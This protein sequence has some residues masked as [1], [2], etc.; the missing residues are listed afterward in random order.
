MDSDDKDENESSAAAE[1]VEKEERARLLADRRAKIMAQMASAQKTFMSTNAEMFEASNVTSTT[2]SKMEWD[3]T[4]ESLDMA[5]EQLIEVSPIAL[6]PQRKTINIEDATFTCILCSEDSVVSMTGPCMVYSAFV[7][8]SRVLAP[9]KDLT[10]SPHIGSCGHVMHAT[11]WTKYFENEMQKEQRR[12]NRNRAPGSFIIDRQEF[13]CPLCRCLSNAVLPISPM[14]ARFS[15]TSANLQ[16]SITPTFFDWL[17][18]LELYNSQLQ[19]ISNLSEITEDIDNEKVPP[20]TLQAAI[21]TAE[22]FSNVSQPIRRNILSPELKSFIDQFSQS[23]RKAAPFPYASEKCEPFLVV[24]ESCAYTIES[25]EMGLRATNKPLKGQMSIR[26]TSCL[27]SL[28]RTSGLIGLNISPDVAAKLINQLRSLLQNVLNFNDQSQSFTEWN[29]FKMMVLLIFLSSPVMAFMSAECPV[30]SGSHMEF[31]YLRLMFA[32]NLAKILTTHNICEDDGFEEDKDDDTMD[33]TMPSALCSFYRSYNFYQ[34]STE[35]MDGSRN[36][37][38]R[39]LIDV[40][41]R[42]SETFLRCSCLLFHFMTDVEL[43]EQFEE[44]EGATFEAMCDYL[45]LTSDV[46]SYFKSDTMGG[47]MRLLS[48]HRRIEQLTKRQDIVEWRESL[49]PCFPAIRDLVPVPNDY[50]DLINSVSTFT[51]PNNNRDDTR[52]PTIC[53]ACGKILCS[54]TY[55]CQQKW[56]DQDVGACTYHALTCGAGVGLF[57]RIRDCEMLLL[58]MNKGCFMSAPYLDEY[59]ETDQGLRRGNPLR[60]CEERLSKLKLRWLTHGLHE[61]I[62]RSAE[63][64]HSLVQTQWQNM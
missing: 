14:L 35:N 43:P 57:L 52:Y 22:W 5:Y 18:N 12:P 28:I 39:Q 21:A 10:P 29:I 23:V 34:R 25:V 1:K 32:A 17:D 9:T 16:D 50:S 37:T 4:A 7:Q 44:I 40:T 26:Q 45:G 31:Y 60:L 51:C 41:R 3:S 46:E 63:T 13:L 38:K 2:A 19:A 61:D 54:M 15:E 58:G 64:S 6:G 53:L 49:V 11:C 55:C 30:P 33:D 8:K 48:E 36:A 59:G 62:A 24:W 42:Y 56:D 27:A 47:F 20:A